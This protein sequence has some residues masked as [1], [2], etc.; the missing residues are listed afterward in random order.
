MTL[1]T[2]S[3]ASLVA[4]RHHPG[5]RHRDPPEERFEAPIVIF[6]TAGSWSIRTSTACADV[7]AG[8]VVFGRPGC[9]YSAGHDTVTP[10]DAAICA[11]FAVGVVAGEISERAPALTAPRSAPIARIQRA[12]VREAAEALPARAMMIDGLSMELL[13]ELARTATGPDGVTDPRSGALSED[14][15]ERVAAARDFLDRHLAD[16][17]DLRTLGREVAL[18][19]FHLAR[20]FRR[21][22]GVAP[23]AYLAN[24]RLDRAAQ[25]L[26]TTRLPV[27]SIAHR[28]GWRSPSHFAVRFR[29]RF[30]VPPGA[31]RGMTAR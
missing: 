1:A 30:G 9:A 19:P 21:A 15:L 6:T 5:L 18:S 2:G 27:M 17:V 24:A 10:V 23:H 14:A 11:V 29:R 26:E 4:F 8:T 12:L 25:L 7:T 16:D 20:S 22:F 28:V 31:Y 3:V 13:A